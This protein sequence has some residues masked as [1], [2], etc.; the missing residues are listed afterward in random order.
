MKNMWNLIIIV[1]FTFFISC[2]KENND[3]LLLKGNRVDTIEIRLGEKLTIFKGVTLSFDSVVTDS[4]CPINAD[5]VWE[6]FAKIKLSINQNSFYLYTNY[7]TPNDTIVSDTYVELINL[8]PYPEIGKERNASDYIARVAIA[9]MLQL[10]ANA[11]VISFNAS[12]CLCCWGWKI[13]VNDDTIYTD[14]WKV[15]KHVG[16]NIT[17]PI[18]V[19]IE[20]GD[21]VENICNS[22]SIFRIIKT[23]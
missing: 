12:K 4:R 18:P 11:E 20:V 3:V 13:V 2:T 7:Y 14:N 5:C 10:K 19:Y 23:Y 17:N 21:P 9:N 8:K 15:G 22:S 1:I 6:G 16:F